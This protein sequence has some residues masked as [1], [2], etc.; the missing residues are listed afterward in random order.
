MRVYCNCLPYLCYIS[1]SNLLSLSQARRAVDDS[2]GKLFG[3]S[4][5]EDLGHAWYLLVRRGHT[6]CSKVF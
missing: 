4:V 6:V 3:D 1:V 5:R 2:W